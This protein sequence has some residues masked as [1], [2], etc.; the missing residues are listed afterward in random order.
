MKIPQMISIQKS[1]DNSTII[2]LDKAIIL[3]DYYMPK[4][5]AALI[6]SD[7]SISSCQA[8]SILLNMTKDISSK[9]LSMIPYEKAYMILYIMKKFT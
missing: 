7:S 3:Y 2:K 8:A 5:K 6:L 1:T 4:D 9:I